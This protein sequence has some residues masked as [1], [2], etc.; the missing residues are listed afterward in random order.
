MIRKKETSR[1]AERGMEMMESQNINWE[2][3][4]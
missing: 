4:E 2:G 3:E 1:R